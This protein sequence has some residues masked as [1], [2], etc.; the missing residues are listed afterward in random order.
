VNGLDAVT[1]PPCN[2]PGQPSLIEVGP[3]EPPAGP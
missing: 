3:F 2:G 1:P